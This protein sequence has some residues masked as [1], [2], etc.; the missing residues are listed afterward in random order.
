MVRAIVVKIITFF[1]GKGKEIIPVKIHSFLMI[2]LSIIENQSPYFVV[3][4]F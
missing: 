4:V 3:I 1:P 2:V